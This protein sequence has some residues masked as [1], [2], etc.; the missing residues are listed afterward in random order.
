MSAESRMQTRKSKQLGLNFRPWGGKRTG[1]GR[2]PTGERAG[3]SHAGRATF[4]RLSV[5]H[6]TLRFSAEVWNLRSARMFGV[7]RIALSAASCAFGVTLIHFAVQGNHI[8]LILEARSHEDLGR[9]M[10][11][12]SVRIAKRLNARMGR[13]G[14]VFADRYHSHVLR[15]PTQVHRAVAYVRN[16]H[17]GHM[18]QVGQNRAAS[19]VDPYS[20]F[21]REHRVEVQAPQSWF[22]KMTWQ[23]L[24]RLVT[25]KNAEAG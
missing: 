13:R 5:I 2:K 18:A 3:V 21:A 1:A 24:T 9:A 10:K 11:G 6:V 12:L 8:H 19:F 16:N 25:G 23:R 7:L 22:L 14:P 20:S 15:T 17:R 4:S